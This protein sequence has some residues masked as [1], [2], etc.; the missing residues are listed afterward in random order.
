MDQ[1]TKSGIQ[2]V[3]YGEDSANED[4]EDYYADDQFV[5]EDADADQSSQDPETK[6]I[7]ELIEAEKNSTSDFKR[8][9]TDRSAKL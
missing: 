6:F 9:V 7:K 3:S 4:E 1:T 8:K 5:Y 2:L